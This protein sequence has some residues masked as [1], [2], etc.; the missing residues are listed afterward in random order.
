MN[1]SIMNLH[2]KFERRLLNSHRVADNKQCLADK[3]QHNNSSDTDNEAKRNSH[4]SEPKNQTS[5]ISSHLLQ[6]Q[7]PMIS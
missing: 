4:I 2:S 6:L 1:S 7:L 3:E 5:T